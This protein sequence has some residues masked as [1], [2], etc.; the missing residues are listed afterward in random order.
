[1]RFEAVIQKSATRRRKLYNGRIECMYYQYLGP[2]PPR[3]PAVEKENP[4]NESPE[5]ASVLPP[6][7]EK[8]QPSLE[9]PVF[10]GAS[11]KTREQAELF[12]SRLRKRVRHLR[13]WPQRGISCFRLYEKDIPEIP[14]VVDNYE[15]RLHIVE[16]ERPNAHDLAEHA[17]WQELMCRTAAGVL[18]IDISDVFLKAKNRQLRKSQ[19]EK[20]ASDKREITV[21]E[22]GLQF[23]VNLSDYV[24]TGLFLDHRLTRD[25]FRAEASGKRVLNLFGYTGA[26]SVYA[27]DGGAASVVHVDASNTYVDWA[28]RNMSINRFH[29]PAYR[30]R[31]CDVNDFFE[32][33]PEKPVFDLAIVDPPT[34]SNS[35]QSEQVWDVQKNHVELLRKVSSRMPT[36]GVIYFSSNFK[37]FQ[38]DEELAAGFSNC[39]EISRQTVPEDF[40]NRR[41]HRCWRLEI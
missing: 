3:Q 41:V 11:D 34:F 14:L 18:Q 22:G 7:K 26:F 1:P 23:L 21:H 15:N 25:R 17:T 30:F 16:Y 38:L 6:P 27:A 8:K 36:G 31:T 9:Q 12:A 19:H 20:V 29:G 5:V 13:R 40:R 28:R 35:K 10:G 24:D 32:E 2:K 33:V 4:Q 37:R 39:R